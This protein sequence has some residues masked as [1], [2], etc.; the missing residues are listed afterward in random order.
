MWYPFKGIYD[1]NENAVW[2]HLVVERLN[3]V[4]HKTQHICNSSQKGAFLAW[5]RI[6]FEQVHRDSTP[7]NSLN[8]IAR[9]TS[10]IN[11]SVTA[12]LLWSSFSKNWANNWFFFSTLGK[13][14][15]PSRG[16]LGWMSFASINVKGFGPRSNFFTSCLEVDTL[17]G[18]LATVTNG[19]RGW[20]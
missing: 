16:M 14:Q 10:Q 19:S 8:N 7:Q 13:F 20:V 9:V 15:F 17:F 2:D 11:G 12:W 5:K 18:L 6:V 3:Y 1:D 4:A